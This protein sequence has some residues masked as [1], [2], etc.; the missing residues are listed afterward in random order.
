[1]TSSPIGT[2]LVLCLSPLAT[3]VSSAY[4]GVFLSCTR[5]RGMIFSPPILLPSQD[6]LDGTLERRFEDLNEAGAAVAG[7]CTG[8]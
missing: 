3:T 5:D 6:A 1:M 7:N 8:N 4:H 2:V